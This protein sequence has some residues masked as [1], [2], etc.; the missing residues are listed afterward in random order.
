MHRRGE[1]GVRGRCADDYRLG[2]ARSFADHDREIAVMPRDQNM[3][4]TAWAPRRPNSREAAD[5]PKL[6]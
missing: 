2:D 6:P 1:I 3:I 5:G 4:M